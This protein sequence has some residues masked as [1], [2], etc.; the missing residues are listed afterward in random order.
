MKHDLHCVSLA[1]FKF[2]S[3]YMAG[4][5]GR[6]EAPL[7]GVQQFCFHNPPP[8]TLSVFLNESKGFFS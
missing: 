1:P 2:F 3:K 8:P 5:E 6:L 4:D 7:A